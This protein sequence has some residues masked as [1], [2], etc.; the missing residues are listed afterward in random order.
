MYVCLWLG[1]WC[2]PWQG[3]GHPIGVFR[4]SPREASL[5]IE[6]GVAGVKQGP[7]SGENGFGHWKPFRTRSQWVVGWKYFCSMGHIAL[8]VAHVCMCLPFL[9]DDHY[10]IVFFWKILIL[11]FTTTL[12]FFNPSRFKNHLCCY[13]SSTQFEYFPASTDN[14]HPYTQHRSF[15]TPILLNTAGCFNYSY[16]N[17]LCIDDGP[18]Q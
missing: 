4:R 18:S 8:S 9:P 3:C 7:P 15:L 6:A 1:S 2:R 13:A 10:L 5:T 16:H 12:F 11:R 17:S 14:Y